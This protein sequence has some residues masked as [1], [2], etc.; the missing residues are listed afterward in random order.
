MA[1]QK[2]INQLA[3]R[4]IKNCIDVLRKHKVVDKATLSLESGVHAGSLYIYVLKRLEVLGII[5]EV[6]RFR[7]AKIEWTDKSEAKYQSYLLKIKIEPKF[8]RGQVVYFEKDGSLVETTI[9]S[10]GD[11]T[12]SIVKDGLRWLIS[13]KSLCHESKTNRDLNFRVYLS[14][15]EYLKNK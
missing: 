10:F 9:L 1:T 11:N 15:L 6:S 2:Q 5:S 4:R 13:K 14:P 8:T 12:F 3:L 7:C